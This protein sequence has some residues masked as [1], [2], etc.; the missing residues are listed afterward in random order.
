VALKLDLVKGAQPPHAALRDARA[1]DDHI[2]K[3][4]YEVT[5]GIVPT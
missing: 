2:D 1:G 3:K 4:G 5:T